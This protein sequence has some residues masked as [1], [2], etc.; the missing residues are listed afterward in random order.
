MKQNWLYQSC[1]K[2]YSII[3]KSVND[4]GHTD[5]IKMHITTRLDS[6]PV[7]SRPYPVALKHHDFLK[8]EI[9]HSLDMGIICKSMSSWACP[10]VVVK[11]H[12]PEGSPQQFRICIDY[13]K[14]N[15]LL[16][17]VIPVTGTRKDAF[18][19]MPSPKIDELFTLF[20]GAWYF[21]ALDLCSSY[22]HI[23]LDEESIPK[24][25]FT[26]VFGKFKFL[27]FTI[28]TIPRLRLLHMIHIWTFQT[29]QDLKP[30]PRLRLLSIPR[31]FINLL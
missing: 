2:L 11:K 13:R 16:P 27:R 22:Y 8:Q 9:Q 6:A 23:K 29:Q 18:A 31:W 12:T 14:L 19:L 30:K 26:T 7:A 5:L 1:S 28:W 3:S 24:S 15:S 21:T 17:S 10:I 20:K 25:A 4:I